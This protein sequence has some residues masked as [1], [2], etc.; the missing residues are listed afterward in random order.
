MLTALS[1]IELPVLPRFQCYK[2][3]TKYVRHDLPASFSAPGEL[4]LCMLPYDEYEEYE[5]TEMSLVE[6]TLRELASC[7]D[8]SCGSLH[9]FL[10]GS[11]CGKTKALLDICRKRHSLYLDM[12]HLKSVHA[13][14][15]EMYSNM[16][17]AC[18]VSEVYF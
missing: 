3:K 15:Q 7:D 10:G 16:N 18:N 4:D 17:D 1:G 2:P 5:E 9:V 11:G 6:E 14:I 13:D 12:S 8:E